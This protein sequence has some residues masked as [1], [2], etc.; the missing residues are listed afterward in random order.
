MEGMKK[1]EKYNYTPE[2]R[3]VL[4]QINKVKMTLNFANAPAN[5]PNERTAQLLRKHYKIALQSELLNLHTALDDWIEDGG[6]I[7]EE[8]WKS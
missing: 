5:E 8:P 1:T 7:E 2:L 3:E 6:N 4:R